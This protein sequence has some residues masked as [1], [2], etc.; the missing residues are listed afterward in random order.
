MHRTRR[1]CFEVQGG[2]AFPFAALPWPEAISPVCF[3]TLRHNFVDQEP[4]P[5]HSPPPNLPLHSAKPTCHPVS[6]V[7]LPVLSIMVDPSRRNRLVVVVA[8][9]AMA[10]GAS[11]AAPTLG[12]PLAPPLPQQPPPPQGSAQP[13][14]GS[15][16]PPQ[17]SAPPPQ[18]CNSTGGCSVGPSACTVDA[19][20]EHTWPGEFPCLWPVHPVA[21]VASARTQHVA[22]ATGRSPTAL[23]GSRPSVPTVHDCAHRLLSL[24]APCCAHPHGDDIFLT[25]YVTFQV[26]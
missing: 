5:S 8:F 14:R 21:H 20:Q 9:A 22:C 6:T 1:R 4:L 7:L 23:L 15:G 18:L 26:V 25:F 13:P 12:P 24:A 10:A 2:W 3:V 11:A 17:G 19:M 16:A